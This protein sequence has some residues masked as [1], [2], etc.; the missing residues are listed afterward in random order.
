MRRQVM[1]AMGII[2]AIPRHQSIVSRRRLMERC[3]ASRSVSRS[4]RVR[5]IGGNAFVR[6]LEE[7][8]SGMF[9]LLEQSDSAAIS[10]SKV[11]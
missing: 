6:G 1:T 2:E 5:S 3:A 10:P 8:A 11:P 4:Q 7:P 9:D